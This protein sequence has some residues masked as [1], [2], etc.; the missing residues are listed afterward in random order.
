MKNFEKGFKAFVIEELKRLHTRIMAGKANKSETERFYTA[1]RYLRN[2]RDS[3]R[4]GKAYECLHV[5]TSSRKTK[6]SEQGKADDWMY[7][8]G[9][10]VKVEKKTNTTRIGGMLEEANPDKKLIVF[11]IDFLRKSK[12]KDKNGKPYPEKHLVLAPIVLT[13]ADFFAIAEFVGARG[14]LGHKGKNDYEECV[15]GEKQALCNILQDYPIK[16]N[17]DHNYTWEEIE[18]GRE[19]IRKVMGA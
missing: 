15:R 18:R 12:G 17:P 6:C 11:T 4:W 3:G 13:Y 2:T 10:L 14:W 1:C 7:L 16:F 9:R 8:C 5:K 19:W